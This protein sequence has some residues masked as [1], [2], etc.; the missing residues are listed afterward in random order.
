MVAR[1]WC[2]STQATSRITE[3][4][5]RAD[6]CRTRYLR[7]VPCFTTCGL[8]HDSEALHGPEIPAHDSCGRM[9]DAGERRSDEAKTAGKTHGVRITG[10]P[11]QRESGVVSE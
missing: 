7:R 6:H 5:W 8:V 10:R 9:A 4:A 3:G 1:P 2:D 11:L